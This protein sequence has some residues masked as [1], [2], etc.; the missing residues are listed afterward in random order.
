MEI[1]YRGFEKISFTQ[2]NKDYTGAMRTSE[3]VYEN[4]ILPRR[5]TS[6]SAGY[7]FFAPTDINLMPN[8]EI[9]IPTGLKVY[10]C[11]DEY[12]MIV[13]RSSMGFKYYMRLANTVAIID[14]DY[15]NNKDNEG[16]CW[17]KIRNESS[18]KLEIKAGQAFAQGIF[19]TYLLADNNEA[20]QGK[21]RTGGIG[22]TG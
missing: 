7:D 2:W 11:A 22:S 21:E 14:S 15:Y 4:I 5:S 1:Q 9:K 6:S 10:M 12:L 8:Q 20:Y 19:Q 3:D 16:H 18:E 13:P 17:I